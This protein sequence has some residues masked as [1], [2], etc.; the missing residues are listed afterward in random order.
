MKKN[1]YSLLP[2][3]VALSLLLF[4]CDRN[5]EM[6]SKEIF[7][8]IQSLGV[9]DGGEE[10]VVR[11]ASEREIATVSTPLG[12]SLLLEMR[13]EPE[14]SP[15]RVGQ[16]LPLTAGAY[17]RVI[18]VK[19]DDGTYVSHGDFIA[20][21]GEDT[22]VAT[23]HIP[24]NTTY[25]FIC[26]SYNSTSSTSLPAFAPEEGDDLTATT[27]GG[28]MQDLL[29]WK[30]TKAV[31]TTDPELEITLNHV[32]ARV[33]VIIDCSYN[34]W[35][36]TDLDDSG[37][38]LGSVA[39]DGPVN[40]LSGMVSGGGD[41]AITWPS[42]LVTDADQQPSDLLYVM[43]KTNSELTI[44]IPADAVTIT[45][46]VHHTTIPV[47][48]NTGKITAALVGG[49]SYNLHVKLKTPVFAGSNIYWDNATQKLMFALADDKSKEGYQGVFFRWGSLVGISP[50]QPTVDDDYFSS[51]VPVYVPDA[52][53][54]SGWVVSSYSAWNGVGGI[55]YW[56]HDTY[57]DVIDNVHTD[58]WVGDICQYLNSAYRLP[59]VSEFGDAVDGWENRTD[60]WVVGYGGLANFHSQNR[61]GYADGTAD[62]L[63]D[64]SGKN[65]ID[66]ILG[67]AV[68]QIMGDR[69]FPAP[70]FRVY[71]NGRLY[72]VGTDANY[73]TS[74]AYDSDRANELYFGGLY[75]YNSY[76]QAK[77]FRNYA[78]PVRC[79]K[80]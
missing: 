41:Q 45:G 16:I 24:D 44:T 59:A 64:T 31:G 65:N 61:A 57:G 42:T 30:Q 66:K 36:I 78:F 20:G 73:W 39:D 53:A 18:A 21:P 3:V 40:L 67:S 47:A 32:M 72:G 74:W 10:D 15:L 62:L 54:T 79:V 80:K 12:G 1:K 46:N 25:D 35:K 68:N 75:F 69:I 5:D 7:V 51:A 8:R 56:D 77:N 28:D 17:F 63:D 70:G 29:W 43:A 76:D 52:V 71:S 26:Y 11:S 58:D 19:H 2:T 49:K 37:I 60:G 27:L 34:G 23:F 22:Q 13:M 50:A 9:S 33:K 38:T 14:T 48:T 6:P 55:P 4:A